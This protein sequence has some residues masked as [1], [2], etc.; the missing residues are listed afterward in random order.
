[1]VDLRDG[2][3][4][5]IFDHIEVESP[6][7]AIAVDERISGQTQTLI[8]F[9]HSGRPGRVEGTRELVIGQTPL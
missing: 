9:P 4:E 2:D 8:E 5:A 1:M 3:R 6:R 7:A